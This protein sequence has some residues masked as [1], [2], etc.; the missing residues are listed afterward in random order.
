[1]ATRKKKKSASPTPL[2][3]IKRII[4]RYLDNPMRFGRFGWSV[5]RGVPEKNIEKLNLMAINN[6]SIRLCWVFP[7]FIGLFSYEQKIQP[8]HIKPK[9]TMS[10]IEDITALIGFVP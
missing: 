5:T 6:L 9:N 2:S 1:M 8:H 4:I 7:I 10:I 3:I